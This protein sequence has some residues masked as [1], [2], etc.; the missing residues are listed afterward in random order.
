[1]IQRKIG[2]V[3]ERLACDFLKTRGKRVIAQNY[4]S[5]YGEIDIIAEDGKY[6]LFIEVKTR[7]ANSFGTPAEA[8]GRSKIKKIIKTAYDYIAKNP[9]KLQPRFDVVEIITAHTGVFEDVKIN[10]IENAFML[11]APYEL[12]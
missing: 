8:V 2:S 3:G 4:H 7:A 5:R 9:T 1:M 12:F 10:Y 11:E 6:I